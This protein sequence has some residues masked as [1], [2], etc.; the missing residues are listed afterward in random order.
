MINYH[1]LR[2]RYGTASN[3]VMNIFL[4][5][6]TYYRIG[7]LVEIFLRLAQDPSRLVKQSILQQAGMFISTLP[8]KAVNDVILGHYCSVAVGPTGD[9]SVDAELRYWCAYSFPAVLHTL[10]A[11][12]WDELRGVYHTLVEVGWYFCSHDFTA[13]N[14]L[15][16]VVYSLVENRNCKT[17]P[18]SLAT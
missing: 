7:V 15:Q 3:Y 5:I 16:I 17:N 11:Q 6:L 10:G 9:I 12:R 1:D 13:T 8:S 18:C 2:D 4:S 14:A